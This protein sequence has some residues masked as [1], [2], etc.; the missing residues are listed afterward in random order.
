VLKLSRE[1]GTQPIA[2]VDTML[3]PGLTGKLAGLTY[4]PEGALAA[5]AAR[6]GSAERQSPSCPASSE[7]GSVTVGAGAGPAPYY[8]SGRAYLAGPYKGAPLSLAIVTP[9]AAGPYDLGTVVVRAAL[10]VDP[11]T[12]R[13]HAISDPIPQILQGI[14]LDV[15]S[16]VLRM[17]RPNFTLNPTSCDPMELTGTATSPFGSAAVLKSPFQV[18]GCEALPFKPKLIL[19]LSGGTKRGGHPALKAVLTAKPGEA[20]I[21]RSVVALPHSEFLEQ[22]HIKTICTRVQFAAS[23][24]PA[25]SIYG[26]ATAMTP[27]LDQPLSGPVYLRSSSHPLPDLVAD[28]NG[29]IHIALVGRVDSVKG[30]IRTS[31]E[32]VPDAPVSKFVLSMQGGKKGL[33]V[34]SRNI[35]KGVNKATVQMDGQNGKAYDT[36]PVLG[37][38]C[39]R[40]RGGK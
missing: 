38:K 35:C 12:A 8:T 37:T 30:G 3:P 17:D 33:L 18:G 15:R 26:T 16:I 36:T 19:S 23:Q 27:L 40:G 11:E 31:F 21:A 20:G 7:V 32:G 9:A 25:G 29:Q 2:A 13:I 34:N 10:N 1:D 14:P 39:K 22:A 6:S 4:C 5:A 24:C 28:L